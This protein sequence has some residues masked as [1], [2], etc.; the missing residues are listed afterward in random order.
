MRMR[1][2]FF[3]VVVVDGP[4]GRMS[5]SSSFVV[6]AVPSISSSNSRDSM[7]LNDT[8]RPTSII[9]S[10]TPV[11]TPCG[12]CP[13]LVPEYVTF[14]LMGSTAL[15]LCSTLILIVVVL[16][17]VR[18]CRANKKRETDTTMSRRKGKIWHS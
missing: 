6:V 1:I 18:K 16:G 17:L 13:Q 4:A 12:N 8:I 10:C 5:E 11:S 2:Y 3:W 9:A 7:G 14:V 15:F